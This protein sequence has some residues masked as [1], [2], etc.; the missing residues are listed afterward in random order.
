ESFLLA[1]VIVFTIPSHMA[2][3]GICVA[4]IAALWLLAQFKPRALPKPRL[5]FAEGSIAA[6]IALCPTSNLAITG[7]FAFTPGGSSFLFGRLIEDGIVARY[8]GEH[9]PDASLRLCDFKATLPEDADDW[10]W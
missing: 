1:V 10:L 7:N 4:V 8:L 9:C 3:A 5:W 2:A 6:G